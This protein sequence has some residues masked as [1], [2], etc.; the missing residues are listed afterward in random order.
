MLQDTARRPISAAACAR[1]GLVLAVPVAVYSALAYWV[2]RPLHEE[3]F[4]QPVLAVFLGLDHL[5]QAPG[6]AIAQ[7]L[8]LRA[9]HHTTTTVW[10]FSLVANGL[11][12]FLAGFLV[13]AYSQRSARIRP[14][15]GERPAEELAARP[16]CTRRRFLTGGAKA[17]GIGMA[18]GMGYAFFVEPR[19]LGVSHR[20][21]PIRGLPAPLDGL[22]VLQLTDIHHGPW[23]SLEY[24]QQVVRTANDLQPD[25]VCLTGDYVH[26]SEAYID[27][28]IAE[29]AGLR[30]RIATVAVLG[31]HDWWEDVARM[32]RALDRAGIPLLDNGRRVLTPERRL[33]TDAGEGLA[34]CGVG[35]L[36]E[37]RQDYTAALGGLPA[38]MPRLLLSHN[39]DV[40]EEPGLLLSG[41]RVDLMLSGHTHGGQVRFPLLGPPVTNSRFGR[42]YAEG[43]VEG[44]V[45]RVFICRGIGVSGFPLR[46]GVPPEIAMLELKATRGEA[47]NWACTSAPGQPQPFTTSF[48]Q[49]RATSGRPCRHPRRCQRRGTAGISC[50]SPLPRHRG[51]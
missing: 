43:L 29:L 5:L 51:D 45:C 41:L 49:Q 46:L 39:P 35:D 23:L 31:N 22:R 10:I 17:L 30:P 18:G 26:H 47:G 11:A 24:V 15:D 27:P 34:I 2:L 32:R 12:Y 13:R 3:A 14:V 42:K 21:I 9:G 4:C 33:T 19:W 1:L 8:G 16:L 6:L 50:P 28:V 48:R 7:R 20:E 44:P 36:W 25:L 37:D 40:A 38:A